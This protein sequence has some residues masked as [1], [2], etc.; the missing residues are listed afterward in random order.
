MMLRLLVFLAYLYLS[1]IWIRSVIEGI[2]GAQRRNRR[3][4]AGRPG[5]GTARP[6]ARVERLVPCRV[7]GLHVVES[8]LLPDSKRGGTESGWCSEACRRKSRLAS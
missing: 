7:C 4:P 6:G 8:R 3:P 5:A 1:W 2:Q